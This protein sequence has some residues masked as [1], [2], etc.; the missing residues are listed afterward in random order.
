MPMKILLVALLAMVSLSV[1]SECVHEQVYGDSESA[2]AD[3]T[4][5]GGCDYFA[6]VFRLGY[7]TE[8]SGYLGAG[9]IVPVEQY[10]DWEGGSRDTGMS[11]MASLYEDGEIYDIGLATRHRWA[12]FPSGLDVGVSYRHGDQ[13]MRGIYLGATFL[14]SLTLRYLKNG[15]DENISFEIGL[16]Y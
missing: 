2:T 11:F 1:H 16:K 10:Q 8:Y 12:M 7:S 15:H 14:A 9:F 5:F 3:A 6:P 13:P 4:F